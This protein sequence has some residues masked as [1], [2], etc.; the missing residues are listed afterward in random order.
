MA[1]K[2]KE[3]YK[4]YQNEWKKRRYADNREFDLARQKQYRIN[5]RMRV[6][7]HYSNND[8]KCACCSERHYE[9][10][11]IDH[12][13]GGGGAHRRTVGVAIDRW[14]IKNGFPEGYRILCHNCNVAIGL[15][16]SCPHN[17]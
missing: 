14:L 1:Y 13:D 10:L 7:N 4:R 12:I 9:F 17:K 5:R 16:G 15:Y 2:N 8:P 11:A 3:D 6:L